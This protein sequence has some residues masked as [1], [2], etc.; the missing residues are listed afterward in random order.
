MSKMSNTEPKKKCVKPKNW[1]PKDPKAIERFLIIFNRYYVE[2]SEKSKR[3]YAL[4]IKYH[5]EIKSKDDAGKI[6]ALRPYVTRKEIDELDLHEPVRELYCLIVT[7]PEVNMF[8]Y[9]M[10]MNQDPKYKYLCETWQK[11][12]QQL[13]ALMEYTPEFSDD[14]LVG[15]PINALLN[16]PMATSDGY[17]CF[18]ND[19]VKKSM[20]FT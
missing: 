17:A 14:D 4:I 3:T 11:F 10:F 2:N 15:F 19:K 16:W 12:I 1:M 9:Q 7:D 6:E 8:F 13:N 5:P 18:L 20:D